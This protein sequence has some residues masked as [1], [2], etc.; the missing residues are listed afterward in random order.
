MK[1]IPII[2]FTVLLALIIFRPA[3][4]NAAETKA[5]A[6]LAGGCF[7]CLEHDFEKIDG[8]LSA[9]SGYTGGE[10]VN[11]SYKEVSTGGTG[12]YEAIEVIYD[13]SKISYAELLDHF[14]INIDP[15]DAGGQFCD[16]GGQY[17]SGIF[18]LDEEQKTA[19]EKSKDALEKAQSLPGPVVTPIIKASTF[20]PAEQY[21]QDYAKRNPIRYNF[22]RT[23]CGRNARLK[24][25]WEAK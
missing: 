8:V 18:Y 5:R 23:T 19:A 11:P 6:I 4:S 1:L 3:V 10:T 20:Y 17:R 2:V 7:W 13:P 15:T 12:H 24:E 14:W 22:Y 25:L 21:H 9:A 16:R